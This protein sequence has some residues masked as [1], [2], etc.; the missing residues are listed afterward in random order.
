MIDINAQY[1]DDCRKEAI[2]GASAEEMYELAFHNPLLAN[3]L[4]TLSAFSLLL[5]DSP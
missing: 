3:F 4:S 5:F 2:Q 1:L